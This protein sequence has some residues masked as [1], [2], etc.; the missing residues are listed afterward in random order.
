MCSTSTKISLISSFNDVA[1]K[2]MTI[3]DINVTNAIL[4]IYHDLC[5]THD[6]LTI[7]STQERLVNVTQNENGI[8]WLELTPQTATILITQ[9][10][11]LMTVQAV[12][13]ETYALR[14]DIWGY[15]GSLYKVPQRSV[16]TENTSAYYSGQSRIQIFF[17]KEEIV[18][19]QILLTSI[20]SAFADWGGWF[21]VVWSLFYILFGS[22]RL[23]PF[24]LVALLFMTNK[25]KRKILK[26][27]GPLPQQPIRPDG[28]D[29]PFQHR[30]STTS[31]ATSIS[32]FASDP[33][34]YNKMSPTYSISSSQFSPTSPGD[35]SKISVQQHS[36]YH[37]QPMMGQRFRRLERRL[38]EFYLNMRTDDL[39][40]KEE[41]EKR[42]WFWRGRRSLSSV[43]S[44][45]NGDE[46][47]GADLGGDPYHDQIP[48]RGYDPRTMAR[49]K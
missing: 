28:P 15:F 47:F 23:D 48:L 7:F 35:Y 24:G 25:A 3:N 11:T 22:P 34:L 9:D 46:Y 27:Y 5:N 40:D 10:N 41:G 8:F 20:P 6:W 17:P 39:Q 14:S 21:S 13:V 16:Q 12:N 31:T 38:S 26:A 33:T 1:G 45:K 19:R 37:T 44:D 4:P 32:S 29:D 2:N 43:E 30:M 36:H 18:Q 49:E 42:G